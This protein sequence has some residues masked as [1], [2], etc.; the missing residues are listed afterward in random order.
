MKVKLHPEVIGGTQ[1][2]FRAKKTNQNKIEMNLHGEKLY[3][4]E[5]SNFWGSQ[6]TR[7]KKGDRH[8]AGKI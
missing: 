7:K 6:G 3:E 5:F 4:A 1:E 8:Y 2:K